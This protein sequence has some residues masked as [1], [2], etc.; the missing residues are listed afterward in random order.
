MNKRGFAWF[1]LDIEIED[2]WD[3]SIFQEQSTA[4][5]YAHLQ[6][7]NILQRGFFKR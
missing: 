2:K 5:G 4:R 6:S 7:I 3:S 1:H